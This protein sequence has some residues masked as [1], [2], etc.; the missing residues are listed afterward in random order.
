MVS[1][2]GV[3]GGCAAE[4]SNWINRSEST[5]DAY[6]LYHAIKLY[7]GT[8]GFGAVQVRHTT[9][10]EDM[11]AYTYMNTPSETQTD[12]T[13]L[14]SGVSAVVENKNNTWGV[15]K[16]GG[17][18]MG[19]DTGSNNAANVPVGGGTAAGNSDIQVQYRYNDYAGNTLDSPVSYIL[20]DRKPPSLASIDPAVGSW[21]AGQELHTV[22]FTLTDDDSGVKIDSIRYAILGTESGNELQLY[23]AST[24][25]AESNWT[26][27]SGNQKLNGTT[28]SILNFD[29][30]T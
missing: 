13:A 5:A 25:T 19:A 12:A 4:G 15:Y 29:S 30:S 27:V 10:G 3:W 16:I 20:L 21:I 7:D 18:N 17:A 23:T 1:T 26:E 14:P 9:S 8:S 11:G 24:N 6:D 22:Q 2:V 28:G